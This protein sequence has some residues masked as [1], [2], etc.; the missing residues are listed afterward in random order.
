MT[1]A[2]GGEAPA[3]GTGDGAEVVLR[4]CPYVPRY[5]AMARELAQPSDVR[6]LSYI[7]TR[8]PSTARTCPVM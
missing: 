3:T 1:A 8:P 7:I 4:G 2:P 6:P 5:P